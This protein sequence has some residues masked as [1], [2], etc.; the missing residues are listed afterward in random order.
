MFA[1]NYVLE[2]INYSIYTMLLEYIE[3][4]IKKFAVK[5]DNLPCAGV[6]QTF[7]VDTLTS[8]HFTLLSNTISRV[9]NY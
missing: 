2:Y 5:D 3:I 6:T 7:V 9:A 4:N 8:N 1:F